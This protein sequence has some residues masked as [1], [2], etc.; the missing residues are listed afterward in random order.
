M[1]VFWLRNWRS[2][3]QHDHCCYDGI[4]WLSW[5]A[6]FVEQDHDLSFFDRGY[7]LTAFLGQR[8]SFSQT[9]WL[10]SAYFNFNNLAHFNINYESTSPTAHCYANIREY[11]FSSKKQPLLSLSNENRDMNSKWLLETH[12]TTEK[13]VWICVGWMNEWMNERIG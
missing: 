2:Y 5:N 3:E 10:L 4:T 7:F 11:N 1:V 13:N 6:I 9:I 12:Q 8:G